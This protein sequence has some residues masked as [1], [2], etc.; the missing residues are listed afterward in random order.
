MGLSYGTVGTV[1][2]PCGTAAGERLVAQLTVHLYDND[3]KDF[4]VFGGGGEIA[5]LTARVVRASSWLGAVF[6]VLPSPRSGT[7]PA[8]RRSRGGRASPCLVASATDV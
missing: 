4:R 1:G 3:R 6:K 7:E 5:Q 8:P 2:R